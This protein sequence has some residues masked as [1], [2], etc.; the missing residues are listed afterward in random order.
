MNTGGTVT[1]PNNIADNTFIQDEPIKELATPWNT[2]NR[3]AASHII[4]ID[5]MAM[6]ELQEGDILG[7]FTTTGLCV[8]NVLI[9]NI[10]E[11]HSMLAFADDL[12]TEETDGFTDGQ[13][14]IFRLFRPSTGEESVLEVVYSN[15]MPDH[16]GLFVTEGISA[17][18]GLSILNTGL[19]NDFANGLFIYPNPT[20]DKVT[21]GGIAGIEQIL[22]MSAEGAV[23]MRFTPKSEGNQ[24]LDLS[25]LKAGFYQV[26]IRT[27]QGVVTR[28]VVK[29]L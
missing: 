27:S 1:F 6:A 19:A 8:G 16:Y 11:N 7:A 10:N 4:G 26:Q 15:E 12:L 25:D 13:P 22:V 24:V 18:K 9:G 14:M 28:K 29:G 23:V 21:I 20:I 3:T 2:I 5:F 17:I